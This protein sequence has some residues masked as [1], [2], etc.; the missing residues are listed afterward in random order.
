MPE[1]STAANSEEMV[2]HRHRLRSVVKVAAG[3]LIVLAVIAATG[4]YLTTEHLAGQIRRLPGVFSGM[5]DADRPPP[6]AALNI[7][8][9]GSDSLADEP[10][11]GTAA[12]AS[13]QEPGG[14]RSDVIMV[15][16]VAADHRGA[17][18]VS[19][20]RDSWVDVPG[21]GKTK[22]NAS[23]SFGGPPLL[24]RT[25]E[26]LTGQRIDH[27]AVIDFA[28]FQA[29][30]DAV[31]GIDVTVDT[32]TTF[33]AEVLHAGPNHL[34]GTEA[35]GYVRQRKGLPAGDLDR[36]QR[37][38]NAL[39]ALLRKAAANG[40]LATPVQTYRFLD[41]LTQWVT[42]DDTMAT[43]SLWSLGW[44]S[45]DLSANAIT[46]LTAPVSGLG[47]EG[48]QSVVYLDQDRNTELWRRIAADDID[49][50]LRAHPGTALG[51]ST[52]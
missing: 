35:L 23:Y 34:N 48:T 52:R 8:L 47:R 15:L 11:T 32:T 30:T 50:Y 45:R 44:K 39:R 10:T 51:D 37:H 49:G 9:V 38:Q 25:V 22:I 12:T 14:Q 16:H 28:G 7:L 36:V 24:V 41:E 42:V 46:F 40:F 3:L 19:L 33:G 31:G 17:T 29:L 4:I 6:T 2:P 20:P 26:G 13:G 1:Q 27:F 5:S 18:V 21:R 43:S